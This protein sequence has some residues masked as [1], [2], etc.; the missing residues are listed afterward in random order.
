MNLV[1]TFDHA[2]LEHINVLCTWCSI[3]DYPRVVTSMREGKGWTPC[4]FTFYRLD[5]VVLPRWLHLQMILDPLDKR[6]TFL[7]SPFHHSLL[8]LL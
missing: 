2:S 6:S 7:R 3:M 8:C 1:H 5:R 4:T